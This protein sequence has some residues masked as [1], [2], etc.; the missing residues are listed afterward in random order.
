MFEICK[1][2]LNGNSFRVAVTDETPT[3]CDP[4]KPLRMQVEVE[5]RIWR[6]LVHTPCSYAWVT[7]WL[8]PTIRYPY[9][10]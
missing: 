9:L 7:C 5:E 6:W 3:A 1:Y 2:E 4:S 10:I 8:D